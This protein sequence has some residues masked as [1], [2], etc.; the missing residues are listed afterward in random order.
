MQQ[1]EFQCQ[2][3]AEVV[4]SG[5]KLPEGCVLGAQPLGSYSLKGIQVRQ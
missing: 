3:L 5:L 2:A 4:G 1:R